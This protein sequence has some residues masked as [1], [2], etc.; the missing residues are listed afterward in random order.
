M[1]R[2]KALLVGLLAKTG[3][4]DDVLCDAPCLPTRDRMKN[5]AL[6]ADQSG[7]G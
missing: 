3:D 7:G 6:L 1:I 5:F 2:D 4:D